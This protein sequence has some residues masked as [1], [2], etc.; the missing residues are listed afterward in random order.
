MGPSFEIEAVEKTPEAGAPSIVVDGSGAPIVAYTVAGTR[1]EVRVAE[2]AGERWQ[3]TPVATLS[4][5]G[6]RCPPATHIALL[7][8]SPSWWWPILCRAS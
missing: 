1:P 4:A 2:R 5:C 7:G 3:I 8:E 6:A